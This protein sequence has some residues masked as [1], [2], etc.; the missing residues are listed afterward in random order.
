MQFTHHDPPRR[1]CTKQLDGQWTFRVRNSDKVCPREHDESLV[2]T[3][4]HI[5]IDDTDRPVL[6]EF[7]ATRGQTLTPIPQ[8]DP[9]APTT[10]RVVGK[11]APVAVRP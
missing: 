8:R 11:G 4:V 9:L 6:E 5:I 2:S 3:T 1:T 10:Y 7:L